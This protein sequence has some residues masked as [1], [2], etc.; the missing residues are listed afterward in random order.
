MDVIF[1]QTL[2][3]IVDNITVNRYNTHYFMKHPYRKKIPITSPIH[4]SLNKW[5][6]MK[7]E[8]KNDLKQKWD[9]FTIWFINDLGLANKQIEKCEIT[10]INYFKDKRVRDLDNVTIKF[11]QD[12][13][14][15]SGFIVK[16]DYLHIES[17][18]LRGRVDKNHCRTEFHITYDY[19]NDIV[20]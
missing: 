19:D 6:N 4:P 16:D 9:D 20:E 13:F 12:G 8:A 3:V 17:L 7:K 10:V 18:T 1:I 2:I 15:N 5:T 14:V 11:F